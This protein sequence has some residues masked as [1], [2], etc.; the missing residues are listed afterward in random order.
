MHDNPSINLVSFEY[1]A[2]NRTDKVRKVIGVRPAE[3]DDCIQSIYNGFNSQ[4]NPI[5]VTKII[6][7]WEP[8]ES[9]LGF[10]KNTFINAELEFHWSRPKTGKEWKEAIA[11]V[12]K[13][14]KELIAEKLQNFKS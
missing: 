8:S 7:E 11:K 14:M 10:I 6:S 1:K 12:T 9:D 3:D 13:E 2:E 4:L 5:A